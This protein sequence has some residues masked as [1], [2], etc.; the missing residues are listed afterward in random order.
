M[1]TADP[2]ASLRREGAVLH[3][4]GRLDR[5]AARALWPQAQA[6]PAGVETLDLA[7]VSALDSAGLALLAELAAR[8]AATTGTRPHIAGTPPGLAD[9]CAA[10]RM[11]PTLGFTGESR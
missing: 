1:A 10:Y 3:V 4:E 11:D 5:A 9:L 2:A 8:I 6:L 7:G